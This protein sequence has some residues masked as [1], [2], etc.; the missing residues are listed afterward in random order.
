MGNGKAGHLNVYSDLSTT[1]GKRRLIKIGNAKVN[2]DGS[3]T[4]Q[5]DALP[6]NGRMEIRDD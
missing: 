4:V 5:L 2:R 1:V 3:L 6:V